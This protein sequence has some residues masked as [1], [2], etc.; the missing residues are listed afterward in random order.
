MGQSPSSG[1]SPSSRAENVDLGQLWPFSPSNPA[2]WSFGAIP[3]PWSE[4]SRGGVGEPG[5]W[6]PKQLAGMMEVMA[7]RLMDGCDEGG[8]C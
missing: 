8:C 3:N 4:A 7:K 5:F 1:P 2:F 6:L